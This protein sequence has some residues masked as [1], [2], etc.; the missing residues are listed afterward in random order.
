MSAVRQYVKLFQILNTGVIRK[1]I[2][3][4]AQNDSQNVFSGCKIISTCLRLFKWLIALSP[5]KFLSTGSVFS[6]NFRSAGNGP[7]IVD[8][9][10]NMH[11]R[12]ARFWGQV[13]SRVREMG[14]LLLGNLGANSSLK[15]RSLISRPTLS[16]SAIVTLTQQIKTIDSNNVLALSKMC[17]P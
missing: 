4:L 6:L 7:F 15:C 13:G 12:G 2:F 16:K 11:H 8:K 1:I 9:A 17:H 14:P 3:L 5:D 10:K